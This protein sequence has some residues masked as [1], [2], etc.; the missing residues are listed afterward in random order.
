MSSIGVRAEHLSS[1]RDSPR[2]TTLFYFSLIPLGVKE[3]DVVTSV[4]CQKLSIF[5]ERETIVSKQRILQSHIRRLAEITVS[6]P[7]TI[8][9]NFLRTECT[10]LSYVEITVAK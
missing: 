3:H 9:G 4:G 8:K 6:Y 10:F 1:W 5:V 7:I 2:K